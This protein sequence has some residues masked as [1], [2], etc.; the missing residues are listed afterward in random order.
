VSEPTIASCT[1]FAGSR[2]IAS[3]SPREVALR[4]KQLV[5]AGEQAP[6]LAFDDQT[7]R[8]VE[9]DLR[10]SLE[11]VVARL[12][13]LSDAMP[14]T[15]P[16]P[17]RPKLGVVAR[18][19]TLLP[20]H[21]EWLAEQP[22][23]ASVTLRRLV[24]QARQGNGARER[25]R[26]AQDATYRFMQA[27]AG[28]MAGFEEASRALFAADAE[29]FDHCTQA[30]P[31]DIRDYARRMA[32]DALQHASGAAFER[33]LRRLSAGATSHHGIGKSTCMT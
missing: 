30:W 12:H 4:L 13:P 11:Q 18:E 7:G 1:A 6:L 9:F 8:H 26:R 32:S 19:V 22:G 16:R 24:D 27:M 31:A 21:W 17:G 10:G 20:R 3:G 28:D 14:S 2:R 15:R 33:T 5:D 29:R 25:Q 23:G